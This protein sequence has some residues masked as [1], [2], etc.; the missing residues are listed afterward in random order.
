MRFLSVLLVGPPQRLWRITRRQERLLLGIAIA[1]LLAVLITFVPL[2]LR[3]PIWFDV[4]VF[5]IFAKTLLRDGALYQHLFYNAFPGML[6]LQT[7]VRYT[8]GWSDEAIR[9]VDFLVVAGNVLLLSRL[10][11][12]GAGA[13]RRTALCGLLFCFYFSTSEW[14][15]CQRDT[16]MLLPTLAA[17]W[18]RETEV[19][20]LIQGERLRPWP[21]FLEGICW[22]IGFL[23]KPFVLVAAAPIMLTTVVIVWAYRPRAWRAL[24]LDM[25]LVTLGAATILYTSFWVLHLS[26]DWPFLCDALTRWNTEYY[27]ISPTLRDRITKLFMRLAPWGWVHAL[28]LP[29]GL[30]VV[31]VALFRK[32]RL[33]IEDWTK[34][35]TLETLLLALLY[36]AWTAQA[37]FLQRQFNYHL[38]PPVLVG[39][40]FIFSVEPLMRSPVVLL[41]AL[42]ALV[43][44]ALILHPLLTGERLALWPGCITGPSTP[45]RKNALTL[46]DQPMTPDWVQLEKVRSF[47]EQLHLKQRQLTCHSNSTI[48]LY[49]DLDLEPSTRYVSTWV[50]IA[51]WPS[52][53]VEI[54]YALRRSPQEYVVIDQ[55][56]PP[57]AHEVSSRP[58]GS[59]RHLIQNGS[60]LV[61][62]TPRYLVL[63]VKE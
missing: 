11:G 24:L 15:H 4:F 28:A 32:R 46:T 38:V 2:F 62:V 3:M 60:R 55:H 22:A 58:A 33:P 25:L 40:A 57:F 18:L 17:V 9:F 6:W 35:G 31:G 12:P 10:I 51:Y 56:D 48:S 36:L 59:S 30:A 43:V 39:L 42:P 7:A 16:W 13:S 20:R 45:A 47:L 61:F 19:K 26:G 53:A 27:G 1:F 21:S 5:D 34:H 8:L 63:R 41:V 44:S 52:H 50:H 23:I 37:N 49:L 14:C 54:D 29:A